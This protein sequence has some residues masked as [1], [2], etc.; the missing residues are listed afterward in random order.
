MR[1]EAGGRRLGRRT[2]AHT[3]TYTHIHAYAHGQSERE[4][5][6]HTD[7][8]RE[9]RGLGVK[10]A[11]AMLAPGSLGAPG[12]LSWVSEYIHHA[13]MKHAPVGQDADMCFFWGWGQPPEDAG[14]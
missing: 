13:R 10:G 3:H 2:R 8:G 6:N 14:V 12:L 7:L 1:D 11:R 4:R 5:Y 9:R